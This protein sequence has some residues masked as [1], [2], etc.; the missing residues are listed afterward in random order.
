M[1]PDPSIGSAADPDAGEWQRLDPKILLIDPFKA[2][3]QFVIPAG[4]AMIGIGS[5]QPRWL[6]LATPAIILGLLLA[7]AL[8][9]LTTRFRIHAEQL[10]VKRGYFNK[11]RLTAPLE[12][13]RNVDLEAS[14]LH[15]VLG[16]QRVQVGTGVDDSRIELDALSAPQAQE[17]RGFLL[18]RSAR[19]GSPAGQDGPRIDLT[20]N[21]SGVTAGAA[22]GAELGAG[23]GEA[24]PPPPEPIELAR[25]DY[26]WLRFA[27]LSLSRLV[28]VAATLGALFQ[29][30]D[31]IPIFNAETGSAVLDWVANH[32]LWLFI[33]LLLLGFVVAW[34]VI[35]VAGYTAQW[36][37]LRLTRE[38][39][40]LHLTRGLF[41]T[42]STTMEEARI[43]GIQ[44][45]EPILLRLAS[46]AELAV[47]ATGVSDE[48]GTQAVLPPS[49]AAVGDRVA[50]YVLGDDTPVTA[51]LRSHGGA[52]RRR[53]HVRHQWFTLGLGLLG[54]PLLV[55]VGGPWW[56]AAVVLAPM[57]ALGVLAAELAW[58]HLGHALTAG[59]LV[60]GSGSLT[61]T[62]TALEREGI[63]GWVVSQSL[64]QRRLGL[65]TLVA[66]TA[67]GSERVTVRDVP[68]DVA[69]AF[70][71]A[72]T[73]GMLTDFVA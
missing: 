6:L 9:W 23:Q 40:N 52:A 39:D 33:P 20:E 16:L 1:S 68:I 36:W 10:V 30:A 34:V 27:P 55:V 31:D 11:K 24:G 7:G 49:P 44:L 35:A 45:D 19:A 22:V 32:S 3:R 28:I 64:F 54:V 65:A 67:A 50:G 25:I 12:R 66:T 18:R 26:S 37:D 56:V 71:D 17:L 8:P 13:I 73:P 14:L 46:G 41:T 59:H 15:R 53:C 60:A 21:V 38:G 58:R 29:F 61:R 72:A 63:I 47:L 2:F 48:G 57:A 5:Q 62:R 43:R 69:V 51:G 70:A 4:A 42:N